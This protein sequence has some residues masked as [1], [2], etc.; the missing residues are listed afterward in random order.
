MRDHDSPEEILSGVG[1]AGLFSDGKHSF[2]PAATNLW[3][4]PDREALVQAYRETEL[5]LRR[6]RV[7]APSFPATQEALSSGSD[8]SD[9]WSL[10]RYPSIYASLEERRRCIAELYEDCGE[11]P[12]LSARVVSATRSSDG[13]IGLEVD[14]GG[15]RRRAEA[16]NVIV[17]TGRLS[18]RWT[19]PW[20]ESLGVSFA[21]RRLELGVRIETSADA[22]LFAKL[23]GVDPKL[24]LTLEDGTRVL[25]FCTCRQ[26]EVVRG[27][28]C[29][30]HAISG[31]ADGPASGLS[32]VGVLARVT[33]EETARVIEPHLFRGGRTEADVLGLPLSHVT[34][35]HPA[36]V[37]TFGDHG[38]SLVVRAIDRFVARFAELR[39][40]PA[41]MVHGPCIEGVGDYPI[42]GD[43]LEAAPSVFVAGDACGR[44]RGIVASMVSGRYVG[45]RI[46]EASA[47][48]A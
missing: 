27:V 12:W 21:F 22:P 18:P 35:D 26:G 6:H 45:R 3:T 29:D 7:D 32:S 16:R 23:E 47:K 5:L 44:F 38:A 41:A 46:V 48:S 11:L 17:A 40:D 19:R 13:T 25:T 34:A 15:E 42:T 43:H 28:S 24:S 9:P 33:H 8:S 39:D 14:Q 4:L 37:E 36:M 20:L 1:G 30:L 10:K 31:R 2:Y